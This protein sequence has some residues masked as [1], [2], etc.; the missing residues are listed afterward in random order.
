MT[1]FLQR[2]QQSTIE[3]FRAGD[4]DSEE[5]GGEEKVEEEE[6]EEAVEAVEADNDHLDLERELFSD[7]SGDE[8]EP[9]DLRFAPNVYVHGVQRPNVYVNGIQRPNVYM[10]G[11][12]RPNFYADG[13][14]RP[15]FHYVGDIPRHDAP[16]YDAYESGAQR[17][18][19]HVGDVRRPV[20]NKFQAIVD[21]F[22]VFALIFLAHIVTVL[23]VL[24]GLVFFRLSPW[25]LRAE[26]VFR[27]VLDRWALLI[28][29]LSQRI[30][31]LIVRLA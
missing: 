11:V 13:V 17:P 24:L 29:Q 10:D 19:V 6:V 7:D 21:H 25:L 12:Q 31:D 9:R 14:R 15:I 2:L 20:T 3:D 26:I 1:A 18:N 8:E 30:C 28:W 4:S 5:E 22:D 16:R 27:M 23:V